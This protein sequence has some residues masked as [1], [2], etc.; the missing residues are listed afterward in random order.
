MI[1]IF[2]LNAIKRKVTLL[3]APF[4][5]VLFLIACKKKEHTVGTEILDPSVLL[6]S[7]ETD[8][9]QLKTFT[10][11][12]DSAISMNPAY[13]VLG[14]FSDP[15][16]GTTD[17]S[18]YTQLRLSGLVPNFGDLNDIIIDSMVLGLE[19]RGHYGAL[20]PQTFEVYELNESIYKDSTYYAFTTKNVKTTNLIDPNHQTI[21][22][23]P[24][25]KSVI[26]IDTVDSQLRLYLDTNL[27]RNFMTEAN[28]G[29]SF[30]SN[31]SFLTYFKGLYIKT[32]N[33]PLASGQGGL[34]YFDVNDP[35]SKMTIYYR[36]AGILKRYDFVI[37][38]E[39][40]DFT[41]VVCDNSGKNIATVIQDTISG[42]TEYYAQSFNARAVVQIPGLSN[43]PKNAVIQKAYLYLPVQY[44]IASTY[45]PGVE[46]SVATLKEFGSSD[47]YSVGVLGAYDNYFKHFKINLRDYIQAVVNE[48]IANTQLIISP[49][50]FINSGD[51]IIFNGPNT[52]NKNKPKLVITYTQY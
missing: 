18:F 14:S 2:N 8:T 48:N 49:R 23:K 51:R 26:G 21:T 47:Y 25:D 7:N 3:S 45:S 24:Y 39:C 30:T 38:A 19:Y 33:G 9:F 10:I 31:E 44:Q 42:Q 5:L 41:H 12:E 1:T 37:N 36:Q 43:I 34:L 27:A 6:N 22:P 35:L 32:N 16:F 40:A 13:E 50:M 4:F 46:V 29:T 15:K 20:T 52:T 17:A 11:L 28:S